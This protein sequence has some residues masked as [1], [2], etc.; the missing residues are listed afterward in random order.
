MKNLKSS[1]RLYPFAQDIL[2]IGQIPE[3]MNMRV[4]LLLLSIEFKKS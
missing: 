3:L 2:Q 1:H 4:I